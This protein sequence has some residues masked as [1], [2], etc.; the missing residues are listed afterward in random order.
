MNPL[1]ISLEDI[2]KFTAL[3][4]S[5]D[6]DK[7]LQFVVVAQDIH[8][9]SIL[10]SNLFEKISADIVAGTLSGDYLALVNNHIKKIL[11]HKSMVEYLP[12][13]A[14]SIANSGVY[15]KNSENAQTVDKEEIDYLVE[16][17][18]DISEHYVQRF[19][20]YMCKNHLLFP[21]YDNNTEEDMRPN[22]QA[23]TSGWV[24]DYRTEEDRLKYNN[25]EL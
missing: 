10:G 16:K 3:N 24:L 11:I 22:K 12:F 5:T 2:P 7:F 8:I 9:Q 18:R 23:F 19:V 1:F 13:A 6:K 15:K 14:Y 25:L 20:K 4:A 21:E 17:E